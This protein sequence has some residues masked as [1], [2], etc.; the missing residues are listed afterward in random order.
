MHQIT[1]R[2]SSLVSPVLLVYPDGEY[3]RGG[4]RLILVIKVDISAL[5]M[6]YAHA[7]CT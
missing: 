1:E 3:Q 4:K 2:L 6:G 5:V 7:F